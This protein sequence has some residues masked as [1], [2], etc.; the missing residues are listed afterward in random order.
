[1]NKTELENILPHRQDMMLLDTCSKSS[2]GKAHATYTIKGDEFF[3]R[4]HF[5]DNPVVPGVIL[6]EIMAQACCVLIVDTGD[7]S[8][9]S[10]NADGSKSV[11]NNE[12]HKKPIAYFTGIKEAKFRD[13][14]RPLDLLKVECEIIRKMANFYFAKGTIKV[15]EKVVASAEFS[16]AVV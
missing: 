5:P 6:C 4:G 13:V 10:D 2:D 9:T 12:T 8:K 3:L 14:V 7:K 11:N 16:F 1:M 15:G